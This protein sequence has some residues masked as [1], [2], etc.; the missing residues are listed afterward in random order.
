MR[1]NKNIKERI[2]R[3]MLSRAF[4][5][6]E[7]RLKKQKVAFAMRVYNDTFPLK[8]RKLM[9]SLPEGWLAEVPWKTAG[10]GYSTVTLTFDPAVRMPR[11]HTQRPRLNSYAVDHPF[12]ADFEA[13]EAEEKA[14]LEEKKSAMRAANAVLDSVTTIARAK[15]AW[16]EASSI[17][18][19]ACGDAAATQKVMLPAV[20]MS[21]VNALLRLPP[22]E[23]E[24]A[25]E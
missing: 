4:D 1:L 21:E 20:N 22:K 14:L 5:E 2:V 25:A 15:E 18:D 16:P 19:K 23:K 8:E 6:R 7:L 9:A 13:L 12:T 17:I 10:F 3:T 24:G 11:S